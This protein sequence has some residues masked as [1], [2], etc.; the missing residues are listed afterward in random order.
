MTGNVASGDALFI[1]CAQHLQQFVIG[2]TIAISDKVQ[3]GIAVRQCENVE[4][5]FECDVQE[6]VAKRKAERGESRRR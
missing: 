3:R 2:M 5:C 6:T 1:V 4:N